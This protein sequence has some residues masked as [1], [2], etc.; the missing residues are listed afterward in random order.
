V[1][2]LL[3]HKIANFLWNFN[4]CSN[5][6]IMALL[7]SLG[8]FTALATEFNGQLLTLGVTDKLSWLLLVVP[9]GAGGFKVG[10][11]LFLSSAA[12]AS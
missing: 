5:F 11:A 10:P 9:C 7:R 3:W 4:D 2:G 8:H 1:T 6:L 12:T